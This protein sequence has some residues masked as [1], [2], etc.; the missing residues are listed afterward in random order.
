MPLIDID[1]Q[2]IVAEAVYCY[3]KSKSQSHDAHRYEHCLLSL[4]AEMTDGEKREYE[5]AIL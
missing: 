2:H 5:E 4:I 3:R 1:H